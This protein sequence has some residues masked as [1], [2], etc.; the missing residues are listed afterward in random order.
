MSE[1]VRRIDQAAESYA[2]KTKPEII[3]LTEEQARAEAEDMI[4]NRT[5]VF[6]SVRYIDLPAT[7]FIGRDVAGGPEQ[8]GEM[9]GR[10]GEFMPTL[11]AMTEYA[12]EITDPCALMH[13][14]NRK[15]DELGGE[16]HYI[17]GK[18]L[19]AGAPV[20]A[21]LDFWDMAP[22]TVGLAVYRGEFTAMI[23]KCM[24]LSYDQFLADGY[25]I[26]YPLNYFHAEVY[27]KE[28]IPEDGVI[29]KQGYLHAI[30]KKEG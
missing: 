16:M 11:N 6:E 27:V 19:K 28:N 26:T 3:S 23:D 20:P 2:P 5:V 21:G 8:Y 10:S 29:S 7:R 30:R 18:F 22:A 4:E 24:M 17:V 1:P 15:H 9:W 25:E 12:T 14:S 13:F